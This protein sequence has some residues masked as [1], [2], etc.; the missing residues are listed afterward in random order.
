MLETYASAF[1]VHK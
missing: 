1:I